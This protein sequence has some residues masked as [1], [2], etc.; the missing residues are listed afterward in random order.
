MKM[1]INNFLGI[2]CLVI[3]FLFTNQVFS[4]DW[5]YVGS[6]SKGKEYYDASSISSIKKV[7]NNIIRVSCKTIF[8]EKGRVETFSFLKK[9]GKKPSNSSVI[10]Y[11]ITL[12]E[13]NC[14]NA[15]K[16]PVSFNIYDKKGNVIYTSPKF[17]NAKFIDTIPD[18]VGYKCL[19]KVCSIGKISNIKKK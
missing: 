15:K 18:S 1:K 9:R 19:K 5:I 10:D 3:I 7:N 17:H 14:V 13:F 16:R 8:S 11:L 4:A 12:E 6:T 2:I